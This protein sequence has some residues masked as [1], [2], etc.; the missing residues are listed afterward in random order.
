MKYVSWPYIGGSN[1]MSRGY[2]WQS[3][4]DKLERMPI[5]YTQTDSHHCI[6]MTEQ[7]FTVFALKWN[8]KNLRFLKWT[9]SNQPC[10]Q[11]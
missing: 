1:H 8:D 7:D 6:S 3:I 4:I 5:I 9:V 11:E 2:A 10:E